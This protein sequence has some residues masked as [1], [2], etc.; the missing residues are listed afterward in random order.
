MLTIQTIKN[1]SNLISKSFK[2]KKLRGNS[3]I[4][5]LLYNSLNSTSPDT[6]V[7][8]IA[9]SSFYYLPIIGDKFTQKSCDQF[10]NLIKKEIREK[11]FYLLLNINYCS[12][13][14]LLK[15]YKDFYKIDK[16]FDYNSYQFYFF[17]I[18]Y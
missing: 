11:P 5:I 16:I 9:D 14:N 4:N 7:F 18:N 6:D 10:Y 1:D 13:D 2:D 17:K 12:F 15:D 8:F 3:E